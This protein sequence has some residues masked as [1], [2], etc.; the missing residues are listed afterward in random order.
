MSLACKIFASLLLIFNL[1][2][3]ETN[4]VQV[5]GTLN[6]SI[7]L[8]VPNQQ[9][10]DVDDIKWFKNN[11]R[12][13][14]IKGGT[15]KGTVHEQPKGY[16]VSVNGSLTIKH[17]QRSDNTN[18]Q[19][20]VY[21]KAGIQIFTR[22]FNLR[23]LEMVSKPEI[24][25]NCTTTTLTCKVTNGTD[26]K[27]KLYRGQTY[28]KGGQKVIEYKWI[29]KQ[30]TSFKCTANNTVSEET[31]EVDLTCP[32]KGLDIYLIIGIC[33]GGVLFLLFVAL[34]ILYASSRRR[35]H[36]RRNDGELEVTTHR[37]TSEGRSQ[38]PHPIPT[39]AP[40]NPAAHQPP[41]PPGHRTKAHGH[42]P[43]P[44]GQRVQHPAQ[45][46]QQK[47]PLPPPGTQARQQKGPP[48]PRPRVQPKPP[49]GAS[50]NS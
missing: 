34:L 7:T 9:L 43:P 48:L 30:K 50:E 1:S 4:V 18:F 41:P 44:T 12:L 10:S 28:I 49:R 21:N 6:R 20:V 17:L 39:S 3:Q 37:M 15:V 16:E 29:T 14:R 23:I 47:R 33:G 46:Q 22:T 36:R 11:S 31:S 24:S 2:A 38:K 40:Q 26:P 45:N 19:I 35:M 32:E 5:L 8:D 27:L 13:V 42:R 25:W